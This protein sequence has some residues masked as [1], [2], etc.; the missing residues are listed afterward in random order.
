MPTVARAIM[1]QIWIAYNHMPGGQIV[2]QHF[3]DITRQKKTGDNHTQTIEFKAETQLA[4]F[5]KSDFVALY[6]NGKLTRNKVL[7]FPKDKDLR[8]LR[9]A[10]DVVIEWAWQQGM[11][12][13]PSASKPKVALASDPLKPI[14]PR[15]Q[16]LE[17]SNSD[18]QDNV[19]RLRAQN[20]ATE[21]KLNNILE[22]LQKR[23]QTTSEVEETE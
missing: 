13:A 20:E 19:E 9:N 15:I 5:E 10:A 16:D 2:V 21:G 3:E 14:D 17:R 4:G 22:L 12:P 23:N 7:V 1:N 18:L 11:E 8:Y 6:Q